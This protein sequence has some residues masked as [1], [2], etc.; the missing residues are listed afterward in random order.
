MSE[1]RLFV[2]D[3][4]DFVQELVRRL[5]ALERTFLLRSELWETFEAL[6]R[7]RGQEEFRDSPLTR[8]VAGVQEAAIDRPFLL[9]ALRPRIGKARYVR[10]HVETLE[11]EDVDVAV[12]LRVKEGLV[13]SGAASH[14]TL[15]IDLGPFNREFPK[16]R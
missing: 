12:Y 7:E 14:R 6:V 16:L 8:A 3:Q 13:G 1:L 10:I 11:Y 15:E 5:L 2:Q 9:L 4:R